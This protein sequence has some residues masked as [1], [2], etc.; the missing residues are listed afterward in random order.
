MVESEHTSEPLPH[1]SGEFL[2]LASSL[3]QQA[4]FIES[5]TWGNQTSSTRAA[6]AMTAQSM[7]FGA[8]ALRRAESLLSA[9]PGQELQPAAEPAV[10]VTGHEL[11]E[12]TVVPVTAT[13]PPTERAP[14]GTLE[15]GTRSDWQGN[16]GRQPD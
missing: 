13:P 4:A 2:P 11:A 9:S 10:A 7:R 3:E 5:L 14:D 1:E 16:V 8:E 6:L 12:G 15:V